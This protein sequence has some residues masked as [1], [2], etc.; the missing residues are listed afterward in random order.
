MIN[1]LFNESWYAGAIIAAGTTLGTY[2]RPDNWAWR[3]PSLVQIVPSLLQLTFIW[4]IPESP[5]WLVSRDRHEE[6]FEILVKYHAEGDRESALVRAEF[7]EIQQTVKFEME[8]SKRRWMS[9]FSRQGT[10]S[11]RSSLSAPVHSPSSL[12]MVSYRKL[13]YSHPWACTN[14]LIICT[15][16][17]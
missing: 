9:S 8:N 6:A 1:G 12:E 11:E 3:I 10:E 7:A 16:I 17:F 5:R 14:G 2:S 13:Y 15:G 4:F